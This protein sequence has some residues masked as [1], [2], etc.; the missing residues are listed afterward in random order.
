MNEKE[1]RKKIREE[2]KINHEEH[3]KKLKSEQKPRIDDTK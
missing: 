3:K 1:L 2:L